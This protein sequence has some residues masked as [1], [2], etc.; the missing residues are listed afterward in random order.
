MDSFPKVA[1]ALLV[2]GSSIAIARNPAYQS[3]T[4]AISRSPAIAIYLT[5]GICFLYS[6]IME[7]IIQQVDD[8]HIRMI[9][10][11]KPLL[12]MIAYA[13]VVYTSETPMSTPH[14]V[15]TATTFVGTWSDMLLLKGTAPIVCAFLYLVFLFVVFYSRFERLKSME[16][17][18]IVAFSVGVLLSEPA[19][20]PLPTSYMQY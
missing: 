3:V 10:A 5:A 7:S 15:V 11:F 2:T 12:T 17:L 13:G 16:C 20:H 4:G 9:F 19:S 6:T 14:I 18:S 8:K 1:G